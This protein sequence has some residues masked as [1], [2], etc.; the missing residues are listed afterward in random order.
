MQQVFEDDFGEYGKA[1]ITK[2]KLFMFLRRIGGE[3]DV[4]TF[5][6]LEEQ[7]RKNPKAF[8]AA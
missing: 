2:D 4:P 6:Q 3:V 7:K 8:A 1:E 5:K